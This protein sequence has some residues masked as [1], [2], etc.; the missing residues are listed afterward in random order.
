M[1]D[2]VVSAPSTAMLAELQTALAGA[3][4]AK[5]GAQRIERIRQIEQLKAALAAAQA[6]ECAAFAAGE[7]ADQAGR[8]AESGRAA[9]RRERV[10]QSIAGQ[11]GL[12]RRCSPFQARRYLGWARIL[13]TELPNTLAAL[14]AGLTTE[15]RATLIARETGWLS[16]EHRAQVDRELA[17]RLE[18]LGDV[19]TERAAKHLA[20]RLDPDGAVERQRNAEKDRRVSIRPA[21]DVMARLSALL[22]L[23]QAIAAHQALV[24]H[25]TTL[26]AAG[27][28]RTPGQIMADTL[29][30]RLTGQTTATDVPVELN[31]IITDQT[32]FSGRPGEADT[33]DAEP[34]DTAAEPGSGQPGGGDEPAVLSGYG[35]LPAPLAREWLATSTAPVWLRRLFR[36]PGT[37]ELI[38]MDSRRRC[39]T[40]AQRKF[41]QIRDQV[42]RTPWCEA[43]IRHTDHIQPANHG[44]PTE[45]SNGQG[46]CQACN[47]TKQAPGWH[48]R[49][50]RMP[51]PHT[52]DI[53][54][55]TGHRYR[56]RAPDPP[57]TARK[58]QTEP[59]APVADL[60]WPAA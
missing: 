60:I 19:G 59:N 41:I 16:R 42:C 17:G 13:T 30:Q 51:G 46:Y 53:T 40:P 5:T 18:Q 36:E 22:P 21:P 15:W 55:P 45:V 33:A 4:P 47:H 3:S 7:H 25:A 58:Q 14:Q 44:G 24:R 12:A 50:N 10:D 57:G 56:S 39:F 9:P 6:R 48:T 32:L 49:P 2:S 31:L 26:R 11:L 34:A 8:A 38:A 20:Y 35:P 37:G 43:P 27:D 1:N 54:T 29:V 23:T 52:V 28:P